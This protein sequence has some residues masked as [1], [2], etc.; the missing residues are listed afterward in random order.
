[1]KRFPFKKA[2]CRA[3]NDSS[4]ADDSSS[5]NMAMVD[6]QNALLPAIGKPND[7]RLRSAKSFAGSYEWYQQQSCSLL[8][9]ARTKQQ[10]GQSQAVLL[11]CEHE[12]GG[13]LESGRDT[14]PF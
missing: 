1:M 3:R 10:N 11:P 13:Y 4:S 5:N 8:R 12:A 7:L 6:D 2:R 14:N 9:R